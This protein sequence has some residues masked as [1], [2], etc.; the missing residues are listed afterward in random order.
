[1]GPAHDFAATMHAADPAGGG[2]GRW[3]AGSERVPSRSGSASRGRGGKESS[4]RRFV[5]MDMRNRVIFDDYMDW[6]IERRIA[7]S[8]ALLQQLFSQEEGMRKFLDQLAETQS[9]LERDLAV[10]LCDMFIHRRR[11]FARWNTVKTLEDELRGRVDALADEVVTAKRAL[12]TFR[13]AR[14]RAAR[15]DALADADGDDLDFFDRLA[16][17]SPRRRTSTESRLSVV[18]GD[19]GEVVSRRRAPLIR[20]YLL[21]R[22]FRLVSVW[23]RYWF[24]IRGSDLCYFAPADVVGGDT[25]GLA[26]LGSLDLARV[27]SVNQSDTPTSNPAMN[28]F[29]PQPQ[30][31]IVL[32]TRESSWHIAALEAADARRWQAAL[33]HACM[34]A[35]LVEANRVG[36]VVGNMRN[37]RR[38][39][40][41]GGGGGGQGTSTPRVG[42]AGVMTSPPPTPQW[43]SDS[44]DPGRSPASV[45]GRLVAESAISCSAPG[46]STLQAAMGQAT[47]GEE[48]ARTPERRPRVDT[49]PRVDTALHGAALQ[50]VPSPVTPS[51]SPA[52]LARHEGA[53]EAAVERAR[54]KRRAVWDQ[55]QRV[56]A[57]R[58]ALGTCMRFVEG[59]CALVVEQVADRCPEVLHMYSSL[60]SAV[61]EGGTAPE[62]AAGGRDTVRSGFRGET[63]GIS[64]GQRRV[65]GKLGA[66]LGE[67]SERALQFGVGY[68]VVDGPPAGDAELALTG[69]HDDAGDDGGAADAGDGD[70]DGA[71]SSGSSSPDEGD[72]VLRRG[73]SADAGDDGTG[74]TGG[75]SRPR[76]LPQ[77]PSRSDATREA[78][79]SGAGSESPGTVVRASIGS[80]SSPSGAFSSSGLSHPDS[81]GSGGG[82]GG[83][84]GASHRQRLKNVALASSA[85]LVGLATA[86]HDFDGGLMYVASLPSLKSILPHMALA[87]FGQDGAARA[88]AASGAVSTPAGGSSRSLVEDGTAADTPSITLMG[89]SMLR[90]A[91]LT[92]G[93][94]SES[95]IPGVPVARGTSAP[96]VLPVRRSPSTGRSRRLSGYVVSGSSATSPRVRD[97]ALAFFGLGSP[98]VVRKSGGGTPRTGIPGTARRDTAAAKTEPQARRGTSRGSL[99]DRFESVAGRASAAG[100][101]GGGGS[102]LDTPEGATQS[103]S[104]GTSAPVRPGMGQR[105]GPGTPA[106]TPSVADVTQGNADDA[107]SAP[108]AMTRAA[109]AGAV[110]EWGAPMQRSA[111]GD[112]TPNPLRAHVAVVGSLMA[113]LKN[114][115][116]YKQHVCVD[117][118][119]TIIERESLKERIRRF[120][121]ELDEHSRPVDS[122]SSDSLRRS[123]GTPRSGG[124]RSSPREDRAAAA[125]LGPSVAPSAADGDF[126]DVD[127]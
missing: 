62:S 30:S 112:A 114:V 65:A 104:R 20:G 19:E 47:P 42:R 33:V 61:D 36:A 1:M 99:L 94:P 116:T 67:H 105:G 91:T 98:R 40:L 117:L 21:L 125:A 10:V 4:A 2:S 12:R 18:E 59:S 51:Q 52:A 44:E 17:M 7:E 71:R 118:E 63:G 24:E 87:G 95:G 5:K 37:R 90:R 16:V 96:A 56:L 122:V 81:Y 100:G 103:R 54:S 83:T 89:S 48:A 53:L 121:A 119:K 29:S 45:P 57:Q 15:G 93:P 31:V 126:F 107:F 55:L 38:G 92:T 73:R 25:R 102:V 123:H 88:A 115:G 78:S 109:G 66:S 70:R 6:T 58:E 32:E 127:F 86:G 113:G 43:Y 74:G 23:R 60:S 3:S 72:P 84:G 76:Y 69:E 13:T 68:F 106:A 39:S 27:L 8:T 34:D 35:S 49:P 82:S 50:I 41:D 80:A 28:F 77:R 26:P 85:P 75:T 124:D 22:Q 46:V 79:A 111:L 120:Q 110:D 14:L 9:V 64:D 108:G 97:S 101:A 11:I